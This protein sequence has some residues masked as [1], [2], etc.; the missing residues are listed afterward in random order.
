M[1]VFAVV[2]V[3]LFWLKIEKRSEFTAVVLMIMLRRSE[4]YVDFK[5]PNLNLVL[6]EIFIVFVGQPNLE[7]K[8][9]NS[10]S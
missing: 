7:K 6:T 8:K 1:V 10:H 5:M 4:E 3:L 9:Q 2:V